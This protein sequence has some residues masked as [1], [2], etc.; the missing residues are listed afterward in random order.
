MLSTTFPVRCAVAP[1]ELLPIIPPSVQFMC[2]DG[3]G[4]KL[5]P[6]VDSWSLST[7]ST[8]PGSTTQVRAALSTDNSRWQY[9]DQSS[10]TAVLVHCP[11][12]LVPP[13]RDRTGAPCSRHTATAS[14]AASTV[15]GTTT[16]IGT[17]RKFDPSV[18]YAARLPA[19]NLTSPSTRSSRSRSSRSGPMTLSG[20]LAGAGWVAFIG[21]RTARRRRRPACRVPIRSSH[22]PSH[23][24]GFAG[25][26][27]GPLPG[28]AL[29]Y[30]ETTY[31]RLTFIQR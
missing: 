28:K 26:L 10:T 21:L 8:M 27:L 20:G 16:P 2:V 31:L 4:P 24:L 19:S 18:E 15:C 13:P 14:A 29:F 23:R 12:R 22:R 1:H 7:S 3:F 25:T 6:V 30:R 17:C 5:R 11:A 9:F